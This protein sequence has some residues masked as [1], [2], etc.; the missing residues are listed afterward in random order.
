M[1]TIKNFDVKNK[2][3]LVRCDF[4]VPIDNEGNILDDFRIK[5]ALPT[6]KYLIKNKAKII[7]MS[8]L[9]EPE[10]K[11]VSILKLNKIKEKLDNLLKSSIIRTN[12][13][14]GQEVKKQVLNLKPGQI[15]LLENL[16]FHK[17]ET[18]NDQE[19]AKELA[20][21]GDIYG[22]ICK[23]S[24]W[25]SQTSAKQVTGVCTPPKP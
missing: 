2:K 5:K 22:T 24:G 16:R 12:D 8:H 3:V 1:K 19:F 6:V 21:F 18:T 23:S 13:C 11:V 15:L 10:G 25:T 20:E 4:N 14:I 9:G 17:E 7:L